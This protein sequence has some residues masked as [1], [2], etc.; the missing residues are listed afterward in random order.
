MHS[1]GPHRPLRT[2]FILQYNTVRQWIP[3]A[4]MVLFWGDRGLE[5]LQNYERLG[6]KIHLLSRLGQV[7]DPLFLEDVLTAMKAT[8]PSFAVVNA[9]IAACAKKQWYTWHVYH[10]DLPVHDERRNPAE[11][12]RLMALV[13]KIGSVKVNLGKWKPQGGEDDLKKRYPAGK[14]LQKAALWSDT[15]LDSIRKMLGSA[16]LKVDV[17]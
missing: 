16:P 12:E 2:L 8:K 15:T 5:A 17:Q 9:A 13:P 11:V 1:K 7:A 10:P 14:V 3:V 4:N 6:V